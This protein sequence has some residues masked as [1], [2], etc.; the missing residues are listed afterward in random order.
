MALYLIILVLI[1]GAFV[2]LVDW[3]KGVFCLI[4]VGFLQDPLRKLLPGQ[5]VH[6]QV[7]VLV[8]LIVVLFSA[9]IRGNYLQFSNLYGGDKQLKSAWVAFAFLIIIQIAHTVVLYGNPIMGGLGLITYVAP[10]GAVLFVILCVRNETQILK[11]FRTYLLLAIPIC[12][13]VYLSFWFEGSS[14][15]LKGIDDI[16]GQRLLI[17]DVGTVLYSYSGLLRVGEVAAWHAATAIMLLTIFATLDKR[18]SFRIM[19]IV[20]SAAL[21]G[22]I[23]LTGRRKML[24]ALVVFLG[25]Y[26]FLLLAYGKKAKKTGTLIIV[27]MICLSGYFLLQRES[28]EEA[29]YAARGVS[30][31]QDSFERLATAW[32]LMLSAIHRGGLIGKG[33][34]VS[35]QGAQ[36]FGGGVK[37]VGGAAE[38]GGGKLIVELGL[39]GLIVILLLLGRLFI[40]FRRLFLVVSKR[41]VSLTTY[42]AGVFAILAANI[43]TFM[44]ATQ[45]FG[46]A[47]IL[48]LLGFFVGFLFV[49]ERLAR[50]YFIL[51]QYYQKKKTLEAVD[52]GVPVAGHV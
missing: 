29:I 38:A 36:Y 10:L 1:I 46:D 45:V 43:A 31:F 30:V 37:I 14:L 12:L 22:A 27:L 25:T 3:H 34:G 2:S 28:G 41:Y 4:L 13:S 24:M 48:L 5:P 19:A 51:E 17:Y 16:A 6:T 15:L 47:F 52:S 39:I 35:A 26:S 44:V 18:L 32:D 21:I 7:L 33:A 23:L 50:K 8:F 20:V 9:Y 40:H 49:F 11:V 42:I